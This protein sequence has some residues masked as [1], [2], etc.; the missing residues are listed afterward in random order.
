MVKIG[1]SLYFSRTLLRYL[2]LMACA[3][4]LSSG[5]NVF[6]VFNVRTVE[7]FGNISAPSNSSGS[8]QRGSL[9]DRYNGRPILILIVVRTYPRVCPRR[10]GT[11]VAA[12][13]RAAKKR[14]TRRSR[15]PRGEA[16]ALRHVAAKPRAAKPRAAKPSII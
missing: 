9:R 2:R 11:Y 14:P 16:V 5:F 7:L 3:V 1:T 6:N 10:C 13:P 12:K 8:P 4:R 15:R